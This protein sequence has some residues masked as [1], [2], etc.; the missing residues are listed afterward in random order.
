MSFGGHVQ[1]MINSIKNNKRERITI[2]DREEYYKIKKFRKYRKL[3]KSASKEQ[4][5]K[6]RKKVKKQNLIDNIIMY[7]FLVILAG[8]LTYFISKAWINLW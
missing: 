4:L 3:Y 1:A 8:V 5:E 2:Y 6:V 7:F